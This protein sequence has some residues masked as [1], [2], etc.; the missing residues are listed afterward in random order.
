MLGCWALEIL[1]IV[2]VLSLIGL[3]MKL[4]KSSKDRAIEK[5]RKEQL[6]KDLE[7]YYIGLNEKAIEFE[8]LLIKYKNRYIDNRQH[9]HIKQ[10]Y[11]DLFDEVKNI[12]STVKEKYVGLKNFE[13]MYSNLQQCIE[14][15]NNNFY[16]RE[17]TEMKAMFSN[18]DGKEL[19]EQ[20]Q[21]AVMTD[22]E[23]TLVLAGAGSGKTLTISAKVKYLVERLNVDPSEILLISFT[24]AS[25]SEMTERIQTKLGIQIAANTFHKL[26]LDIIRK[27][28]NSPNVN[29]SGESVLPNIINEYFKSNILKNPNMLSDVLNFYSMYLAIP[30]DLEQFETFGEYFE[31]Q[32]SYDMETIKSKVEN[33][34]QRLKVDYRTLDLERVKSLE[35]VMIANYLYL[36][37][38]KYEYECTYPNKEEKQFS[39]YKPDF[40]LPD[41][42][43]YLEH[44]GISEK[45]TVPWLNKIQEKAYL[46]GIVWKRNMHKKFNTTLVETY[47]YYNAQGILLSKLEQILKAKGVKLNHIDLRL[48]YE[49][50]TL[51][52][53]ENQQFIE[54]KKL[55]NT[56]IMLFK[57]NGF[58]ESE[59]EKMVYEQ[60]NNKDSLFL[61]ERA[62]LFIKIIKPIYRAYEDHLKAKHLIDFNDMIN[63]STKIVRDNKPALPYKYIII[64]EFQDISMG[65]YSLVKAIKQLTNAKLLAVG[66]DWQAIYR[67]AGSDLQLF[68]KFPEYFGYTKMLRIER[69]YRNSQQLIDIASK[70]VMKNPIQFKKN[71]IS[72][73]KKTTPIK[74]Y[75]HV[76]DA[77]SAFKAAIDD[78]L[79]NSPT[80]TDI[81]VIGRNNSDFRNLFEK[82]TSKI[83]EFKEKTVSTPHRLKSSLY[84]NLVFELITA[85]KSK[86]LES[87]NVIVIN[88]KN[89]IIGF[90]NK[91]SDDPLLSLV[92]TNADHFPYAEERRGFYVAITRT[93]NRTYLIA[94]ETD[95]SLF[96]E[97]LIKDQ[98]IP[99]EMATSERATRDNPKCPYC[100][101]GYLV[102]RTKS[103][104]GK[105][106]LGCSN[107]PRCS[108]T[109]KEVDILKNPMK[110]EICDSYM[111]KRKGPYGEFYG[112]VEFPKCSHKI[113]IPSIKARV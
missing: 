11:K 5:A 73:K 12:S 13:S 1:I 56:F 67:F 83:F 46:D 78:I 24:K 61:K 79:A 109:I 112:C 70:F 17:A 23:N 22:E 110:C 60:K 40:Y 3:G 89:N 6:A 57:S 76:D 97:E 62:M 106:F 98:N 66:D 58:D 31:D 90:P 15:I 38:I 104:G 74:I 101:T 95:T 16:K 26:G 55:I 111:V 2:L 36:N 39:Q 10:L 71:L 19:D 81:M 54:F 41:Y 92:L 21:K 103:G 91:I 47:S 100:Q 59:F 94:P 34:E 50:I 96:V 52:E 20:Q 29:V 18:I 102:L 48:V 99:F 63:L 27:Y 93:K 32:S 53:R 86:G 68:V 42:D 107:F 51:Q 44:F 43:I 113:K 28:S 69:T 9:N 105:S 45:N 87:E 80:T 7:Q 88:L 37:G 77:I 30:K 84:P 25:A 72:G 64:D 75:G 8:N 82:D 108:T 33:A 14:I 65:R 4:R 85:H 35:E 49:K